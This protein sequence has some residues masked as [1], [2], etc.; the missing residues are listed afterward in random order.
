MKL[1]SPRILLGALTFATSSLFAF[2]QLP[3]STAAVTYNPGLTR[4]EGD[5]PLVKSVF[6]DI[7]S[8]ANLPF[9]VETPVTPIFTVIA[10]PEGATDAEALD[11]VV[12]NPSTLIFTGPNQVISARIDL[13]FPRGVQAG[14]YQYKFFTPGW[15][16]GTQDLGGFLN[17]TIYPAPVPAE[18]PT[19]RI[20][21]PQDKATFTFNVLDGSISIPVRFTSTA[22][23]SNPLTSIDADIN[24]ADIDLDNVENPDG[25]V[26]STSTFVTSQP[27]IFTLFARAT[28]DVDTATDN[29]EFTVNMVGPP[30]TV[31]IAQPAAGSSYTVVAGTTL[32]VPFVF[33]GT[34]LYSNITSLTASINETAVSFVPSGLGTLNATGV[35]NL[36]I[37]QGGTYILSV[38]ATNAFGTAA[39]VSHFTV[40]VLEPTPPPPTVT[41]TSPADGTVITR[42]AGTPPTAVPYTFTAVTTA[43]WTINAVGASLGGSTLAPIP[44]GL[45]TPNAG[46]SGTLYVSAPGTYSLVATGTS[47]SST[48]ADS[49]TFTVI[50]TAPPPPPCTVKWLAPISG[51]KVIKGGSKV[52][53]DFMLDCGGDTPPPSDNCAYSIKLTNSSYNASNNTT[54]FTYTVTSNPCGGKAISH[55]VIG[56]PASCGGKEILVG[57]N[58]S[59]VEFVNPDPTT[60]MRGV[61]FD[62]GYRD[63]ETR[64]VTLT[65]RGQ[66]GTGDVEIAVKAGPGFVK[67]TVRG[68]VCGSTASSSSTTTS[69]SN[70][71]SAAPTGPDTSIVVAVYEIFSNGT[72]STPQLFTYGTS[73]AADRYTISNTNEYKLSYATTKGK[74]RYQIEVYQEPV[75]GE[76][77]V[78]IGTRQFETK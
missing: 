74:H 21:T 54:V 35:A 34:S 56:I 77:P 75:G 20:S 11:Y 29:V 46:G 42:V 76:G 61:K 68:P 1:P 70:T 30:P 69:S 15:L 72:T 58:D 2:A 9:G 31:A 17:A 57:S 32:S 14:F 26:T 25:S 6:V 63:R 22:P 48:A 51:G 62:T 59:N 67:D 78:L 37:S 4:V 3:P 39:T 43:P 40:T 66:W 41:I 45:G 52:S 10:K 71:T 64:T 47:G 38:S 8:P 24:G 16:P 12:F 44:T 36:S 50:E 7:T 33:S 28:N 55:W 13:T 18:P 60:G 27:G 5:E 49:I 65:L 23:E 73:P 19:V 53:I